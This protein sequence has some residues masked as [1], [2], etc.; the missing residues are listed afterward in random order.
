M[1]V[2][3]DEKDYQLIAAKVLDI[4]KQKYD[5]VPQQPKYD[6]WVGIKEFISELPVVKGKE[7]V[8]MFILTRPEFKPWVINLNAGRGHPTRI[9]LNKGIAWVNAHQDEIN[10]NRSLPRQE[11]SLGKGQMSRYYRRSLAVRLINIQAL[12]FFLQTL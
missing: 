9:N 3:L 1:Q 11:V 10:W 6:N 4:I 7:W 5:L 8:R 12:Q 2:Q